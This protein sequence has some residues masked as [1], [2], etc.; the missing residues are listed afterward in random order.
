MQFDSFAAFWSMGG[1]AFYVWLSYGV[2]ALAMLALVIQTVT[3]HKKLKNHIVTEQARKQ[4]I[5]RAREQSPAAI[6]TIMS[7]RTPS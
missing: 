5:K 2:C 3:G 7:D 4:R 1:Y 6:N